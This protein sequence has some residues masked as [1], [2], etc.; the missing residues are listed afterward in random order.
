MNEL[1]LD[2]Q[3][4]VGAVL[5]RQPKTLGAFESHGMSEDCEMSA[6]PVPPGRFTRRHEVVPEQSIADLHRAIGRWR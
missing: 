2:G 6:P 5:R 3:T 1:M 4:P